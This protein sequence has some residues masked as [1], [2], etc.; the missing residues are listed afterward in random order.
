[1]KEKMLRAGEDYLEAILQ[2]EGET[3]SKGV[4]ITDL[5]NKLEVTKPS[6]NKAMKSLQEE[7]YIEKE[8]Y[9]DI[10]LTESGRKKAM[11]VFS[12]HS[13]LKKFLSEF[14][15]VSIDQA[16]KDAC[17]IEHYISRESL[18]K[19]KEYMEREGK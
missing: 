16:E 12:R 6:A 19:L 9:G 18:E 2:L 17:L 3:R 5:A 10:Y 11:D 8:N 1:M 15:G 4:R 13:M 14:L 7:G